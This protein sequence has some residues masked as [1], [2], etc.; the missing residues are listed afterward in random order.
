MVSKLSSHIIAVGAAVH[1]L[2][3]CKGETAGITSRQDDG[4]RCRSAACST[5][6]CRHCCSR[7]GCWAV[8]PT[9]SVRSYHSKHI[10][11][12]KRTGLHARWLDSICVYGQAQASKH[13]PCT[14]RDDPKY[15]LAILVLFLPDLVIYFSRYV[16]RR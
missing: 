8:S 3:V 9:T 7:H 1:G 15:R 6:E 14:E 10:A 11:T 12:E 2:F 16:L 5:D 4:F 13:A